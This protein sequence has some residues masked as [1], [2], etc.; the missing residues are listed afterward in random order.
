MNICEFAYL[1]TGF[2]LSSESRIFMVVAV[3][4]FFSQ[5]LTLRALLLCLDRL[6]LEL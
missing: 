3:P 2:F 5:R 1:S 4:V 6:S